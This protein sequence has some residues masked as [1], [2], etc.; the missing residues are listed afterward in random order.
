MKKS[1]PP[2]KICFPKKQFD[3][4]KQTKNTPTSPSYRIV[5]EFRS[6]I[7]LVADDKWLINKQFHAI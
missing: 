3:K 1:R 2:R 4:S 6:N 7:A 5:D